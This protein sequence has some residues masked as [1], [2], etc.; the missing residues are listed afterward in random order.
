MGYPQVTKEMADGFARAWDYNGIKMILDNTSR[1]FAM[2]FANIALKSF[3]D[4]LAQ[5]A[6]AHSQKL[7]AAASA[8]G[9]PTQ[10]VATQTIPVPPTKSS[11]ILTD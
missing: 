4:D 7:K 6:L 10:A 3:V 2:D 1:Q 11:I 9:A 5:K 8:S